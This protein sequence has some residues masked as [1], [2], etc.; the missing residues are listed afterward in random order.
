MPL[1]WLSYFLITIVVIGFSA[2]ALIF[3]PAMFLSRWIPPLKRVPDWIL[4]KGIRFLMAVQPWF[5]A[6]VDISLPRSEGG[7]LIVSNHRSVLDVFIL[8]SRIRGIRI[9]ARSGLYKI[10]FLALMMRATRQ[11]RVEK[12]QLDSWVKSL[13]VVRDNLRRGE[14]VHI[15]PEMT[16]CRPGY[17]GLQNFVAAPF[18]VA[19]QT[20]ATVVPLVFDNTDGAWPKGRAGL[21]FRAP[22]KVKSLEPIEAKNF[23][24]AEDLRNVVRARMTEAMA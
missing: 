5:K 14:T 2:A 21:G 8:L 24:N 18:M 20:G 9:M 1:I 16:R 19:I 12:G 23:S 10:P 17:S 13:E 11:I 6:D 22:V 7:V 3:F 4:Q 15:F